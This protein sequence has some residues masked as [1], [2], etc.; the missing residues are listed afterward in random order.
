MSKSDFSGLEGL[1][2]GLGKMQDSGVQQ[3]INDTLNKA[4]DDLIA[5]AKENTPTGD[6]DW[7]FKMSAE[8]KAKAKK[9]E[10]GTPGKLKKSWKRT[11]VRN[12]KGQSYIIISNPTQYAS[13]VEYGHRQEPGRYE[14]AVGGKLKSSWVEGQFMFTNAAERLNNGKMKRIA[15]KHIRKMNEEIFGK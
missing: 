1:I 11:K 14:P 3:V 13:Y 4:A 9:H 15:A 2:G 12:N 5:D 10:P 8:Q 6:Y 7:Y